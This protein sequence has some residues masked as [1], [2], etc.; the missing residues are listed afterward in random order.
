[1][2]YSLLCYRGHPLVR[3]FQTAR[4]FLTALMIALNHV[5]SLAFTHPD[6]CSGRLICQ[7]SSSLSTPALGNGDVNRYLPPH[8]NKRTHLLLLAL[9]T[10]DSSSGSSSAYGS[11]AVK[12]MKPLPTDSKKLQ[13]LSFY[14]FVPISHPDIIRDNIFERLEIIEGLRGTVY[15]ANEGIN[16]QLAVPV[17]EPLEDLLQAFGDKKCLPFD[18]FERN[19]PNMGDVVDYTTSTFDR[20][21]V[22][23]RDFILRDGINT[24][25]VDYGKESTLDWSDAGTEIDPAEWDEQL[26]RPNIQLLDCRNAYESDQGSFVSAKPLNTKTFSDTWSVLESEVNSNSLDP[27]EPVYIFCTGG[28]RCVKVGA[29]LRQQLGVKDVRSLRHG[30]IGYETWNKNANA[31]QYEGNNGDIGKDGNKTNHR[32]EKDSLWIGENF[33]FDKRRFA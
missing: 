16:A 21:I 9:S 11:S 14:R 2:T 15:V 28:I 17:G 29:Y 23:T 8:P 5:P 10:S 24:E 12:S 6:G 1:M 26:R 20:L 18:I 19:P 33:L 3:R 4:F 31:G 25:K 30:I 27:S 22:R 7:P 32:E 13:L